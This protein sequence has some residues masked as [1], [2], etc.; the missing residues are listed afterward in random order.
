MSTSSQNDS[1]SISKAYLTSKLKFSILDL[2][3]FYY[4]M[5]GL[6]KYSFKQIEEIRDKG[7]HIQTTVEDHVFLEREELMKDYMK[8][9]A[10]YTN[11]MKDLNITHPADPLLNVLNP[12]RFQLNFGLMYLHKYAFEPIFKL[13]ADDS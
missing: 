12:V 8:R 1:E 4:D 13:L 5:L 7:S 9:F 10:L 2:R 11:L 3:R 6:G